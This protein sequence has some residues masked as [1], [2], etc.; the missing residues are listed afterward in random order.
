MDFL[1]TFNTFVI[2][3][4]LALGFITFV[5]PPRTEHNRT[6]RENWL[7][8][9]MGTWVAVIALDIIIKTPQTDV[10]FLALFFFAVLC[11]ETLKL[12]VDN[13]KLIR[14]GPPQPIVS[15]TSV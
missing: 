6:I 8:A 14:N 13:V 3:Y 2:L 15:M 1:N 7:H 5:I 9:L 4:F 11:S 10:R 12:V